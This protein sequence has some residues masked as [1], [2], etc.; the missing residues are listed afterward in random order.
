MRPTVRRIMT[1]A[2]VAGV[3]VGISSTTAEAVATLPV[4]QSNI[5]AVVGSPT[6][7]IKATL[8]S[9]SVIG[10]KHVVAVVGSEN[11]Q[12]V[13]V[14]TRANVPVTIVTASRFLQPGPNQ[15]STIDSDGS[16]G[17]IN[18]TILRQSR[19]TGLRAI[20]MGCHR[21]AVLASLTM[22]D[23]SSSRWIGQR[24]SPLWVQALTGG[25]WT[26][27]GTISTN[28]SGDGIAAGVVTAPVGTLTL[29]VV[30]PTGS[31]VTSAT[32]GSVRVQVK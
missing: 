23:L 28:V 5:V 13:G 18:V 15:W 6:A 12:G 29:R 27:I 14:S 11:V 19:I 9:H 30:R 17:V 26:N 10:G 16:M 3:M 21:V 1:A 4:G 8:T 25:K 32:S 2:V 24:L 31:T 7:T 20:P 22:Y